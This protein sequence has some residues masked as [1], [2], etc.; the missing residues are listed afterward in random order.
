MRQDRKPK[1]HYE[2]MRRA[3][4][5][6]SREG[7]SQAEIARRLNVNVRT[8]RDW[9]R[10]DGWR[11][12][13]IAAAGPQAPATRAGAA[14]EAALAAAGAGDL[15]A[16]RKAIAEA[17]RLEKLGRDLEALRETFR[18]RSPETMDETELRTALAKLLGEG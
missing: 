5:A 2:R 3:A 11:D 16:A 9:A 17:A 6:L 7:R 4:H 14:R 1:A 12:K 8:V 13:D 15:E 18:Q 10:L